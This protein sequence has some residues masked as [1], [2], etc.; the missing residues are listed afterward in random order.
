[1]TRSNLIRLGLGYLG[2]SN[3]F[4]GVWATLAPSSFFTDFPG[5]GRS[6]VAADGPYNQHLVRDVGAWSLAL[7]V[8]LLVAAWRPHRTLVV[9]A[10]AAGAVAALPH[11]IYH[12]AHRDLVGSTV[13]QLA[14]VGGLWFNVV[15]GLGVVLAAVAAGRELE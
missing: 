9:A 2:L 6:W 10:G 3:A 8:V 5:G 13:D 14:S 7:A 4:I 1:M 11:A 12:S 15:V